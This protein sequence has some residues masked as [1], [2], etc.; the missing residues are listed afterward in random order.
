MEG[1]NFVINV[2]LDKPSHFTN[3]SILCAKKLDKATPLNVFCFM[4]SL[5][6]DLVVS[7]DDDSLDETI[8]TLTAT[9]EAKRKTEAK[10]VKKESKKE[11]KKKNK[12]H[13]DVFGGGYEDDIMYDEYHALEDNY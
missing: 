11:V 5:T 7:L 6:D 8:R 12:Q 9:R 4:K 3:F 13:A 2:E 1:P 10:V